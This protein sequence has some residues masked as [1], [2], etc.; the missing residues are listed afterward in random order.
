MKRQ[1]LYFL[2]LLIGSC[3]SYD[4]EIEFALERAGKNKKELIEV[5]KHFE[6]EGD[7]LKLIAAKFLIS[8]LP[9]NYAYDTTYLNKYRGVYDLADLHWKNYDSINTFQLNN[10]WDDI[11]NVNP[12]YSSIYSRPI[13]EDIKVITSDY[14]IENIDVAYDSWNNNPYAKDSVGFDDFCEYV[15]PYRLIQ[16]KAIE[17][18]RV[19]F[20]NHNRNYFKKSYPI[21]F[22]QACDS[23]FAQYREYKF[24]YDLAEGLPILKFRDFMQIKSGKCTVK[25]WLNTYIVNSEGIPMVADFVPAWGSREDNHQW[26]ALKYGHKTLYFE[27]YWEKGHNWLYNDTINS[28]HYEDDWLGKIRLPKIYRHTFSTQKE[29]PISDKTVRLVDIPIFFRN[30]KQKDVSHEYFDGIDIDIKVDKHIIPRGTHYA[31][32]AVLGVD[33][34][35]VPVQW[36]K[37]AGKTLEFKKMGT[38]IL[39]QPV[40][41]KDNNIIP[42]G[43]SFHINHNGIK[44][45]FHP[46]ESTREIIVKRKYPASKV[47]IEEAGFL[48]GS[49]IQGSNSPKF[50]YSV[51]LGNIDFNPELRFYKLTI[52][53]K[54]KYR[55]FRII[56]TNPIT[57]KD[58]ELISE[59]DA[60]LSTKFIEGLEISNDSAIWKGAALE[61]PELVAQLKFTPRSSLN[62]V[63]EGLNYELYY[64]DNG[65]FVS[66]GKKKAV[67]YELKYANVPENALLYLKCLDEGRQVR[68]FEYVNGQ[69]IW[70]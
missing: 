9:Y 62:H 27:S 4:S 56:S 50:E 20:K 2:F 19:F 35:W 18:W 14:L 68:L 49:F 12:P 70:Y 34:Q 59:K 61:K 57:V 11:K 52:E 38:D 16:G 58:I 10:F 26:N 41:F 66:L 22:T 67:G 43:N 60:V 40:F 44:K 64:L 23:L 8:N 63:Y 32:L 6:E 48:K 30:R 24:N 17:N 46:E 45:E 33:K 54:S 53:P 65:V 31:Y 55:Y 25:S 1:F 3:Y 47:L 21:P 69:Q 15:L 28:N 29:G 7:S 5:L 39:Y 37:L 36:A 42:F 51:N 13:I